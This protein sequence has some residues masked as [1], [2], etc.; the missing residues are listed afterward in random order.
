[1]LMFAA[2]VMA[3]DKETAAAVPEPDLPS[4]VRSLLSALMVPVT[5]MP[6]P[7]RTTLLVN[8]MA[9]V[10][11]SDVP[12]VRSASRLMDALLRLSVVPVVS[13]PPTL[14]MLAP[15]GSAVR[16]AAPARLVVLGRLICR[17]VTV[18]SV[19]SEP[20]PPVP[21]PFSAP[22]STKPFL[23]AVT[24]KLLL[25]PLV[26]KIPFVPPVMVTLAPV[27]TAPLLV[28]SISTLAALICTASSMRTS[29]PAVTMGALMTVVEPEP[30]ISMPVTGP[31]ATVDVSAPVT[32]T[33]APPPLATICSRSFTLVVPT[34]TAPD[35][36]FC[37]II[38]RLVSMASIPD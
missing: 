13:A 4:S 14:M 11:A 10:K 33:L 32:K 7:D 35:P 19:T 21:N 29:V 28:V 24:T 37:P 27:G 20:V 15:V 3:P 17:P 5:V 6:S 38:S 22:R 36:P 26:A 18:R 9:P 16:D 34:V 31:V 1:M 30:T 2:L 23:P 8:V 12:A 25:A